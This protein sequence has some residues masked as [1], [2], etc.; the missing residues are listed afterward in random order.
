VQQ[1]G[2]KALS[3]R[4]LQSA[5]EVHDTA[6]GSLWKASDV[7]VGHILPITGDG[8]GSSTGSIVGCASVAFTGDGVGISVPSN[9]AA[10]ATGVNDASATGADVTAETGN[11]VTTATGST[12][13]CASVAF[14]GDGVG[15][16]VPLN[17][18]AAATGTDDASATGAGVTAEK[19]EIDTILTTG[20]I[21]S[22]RSTVETRGAVG[23]LG[24][25]DFPPIVFP[26]PSFEPFRSRG[27]PRS[28]APRI[29]AEAREI[30]ETR[31]KSVLILALNDF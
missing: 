23:D 27:T 3:S 18:A 15:I 14:T 10:A 4:A 20:P 17:S 30:M 11:D 7:E 16:S 8:I 19:G 26:M 6:P 2:P 9:S 22:L 25:E 21:G 12:V 31:R 1:A 5:L 24:V 28:S 29:V 13:G